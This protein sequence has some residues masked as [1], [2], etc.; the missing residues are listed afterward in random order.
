MQADSWPGC[1]SE[2][3]IYTAA[4]TAQL[5][6]VVGPRADDAGP[7]VVPGPEEEVLVPEGV[8]D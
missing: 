3:T 8:V 1:P 2:V 4:R 6:L 7:V 5:A